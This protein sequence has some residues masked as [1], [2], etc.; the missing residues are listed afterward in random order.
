MYVIQLKK[1]SGGK[2]KDK[3][4]SIP[5]G[6]IKNASRKRVWKTLQYYKKY[7]SNPNFFLK[8]TFLQPLKTFLKPFQNLAFFRYILKS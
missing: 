5:T 8:K 6:T 7:F 4:V 3:F 1:F 2:I